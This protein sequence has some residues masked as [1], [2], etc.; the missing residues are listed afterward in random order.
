MQVE[1]LQIDLKVATAIR[2]VESTLR[3]ALGGMAVEVDLMVVAFER[4]LRDRYHHLR[5]EAEGH[6]KLLTEGSQLA[7]AMVDAALL[8]IFVDKLVDK[9]LRGEWRT[10]RLQLARAGG[11]CTALAALDAAQE[12]IMTQIEAAS[13]QLRVWTAKKRAAQ[14]QL[15][16]QTS[17]RRR[18]ERGQS[19]APKD[20]MSFNPR[21]KLFLSGRSLLQGVGPLGARGQCGRLGMLQRES[22]PVRALQ[23]PDRRPPGPHTL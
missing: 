19:L 4:D 14:P 7:S 3:V 2:A 13:A 8:H 17:V 5:G 20:P 15:E 1:L 9:G 18:V 22:V 10:Q 12:L 23:R 6:R 11:E 16:G 21:G